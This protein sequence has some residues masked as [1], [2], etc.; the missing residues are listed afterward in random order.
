MATIISARHSQ[1]AEASARISHLFP[2]LQASNDKMEYDLHED[3]SVTLQGRFP[4]EC[5]KYI[6]LCQSLASCQLVLDLPGSYASPT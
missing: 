6:I 3:Q 1:I 5:V 4:M 2:I